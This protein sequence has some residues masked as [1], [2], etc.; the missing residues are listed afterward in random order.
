MITT[1]AVKAASDQPTKR[2][3]SMAKYSAKL[4]KDN[5]VVRGRIP[6]PLIKRLGGKAGQYL[7]FEVDDSSKTAT[8]S[9]QKK[10]VSKKS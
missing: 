2:R 4:L 8:I 6:S 10:R 3:Q 5:N 9:L 1:K 7:V